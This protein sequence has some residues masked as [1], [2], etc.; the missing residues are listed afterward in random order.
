VKLTIIGP[1]TMARGIG[2]RALAGGNEVELIGTNPEVAQDLADELGHGAAAAVAVG[3]EVVVLALPY[4][5]IADAVKEHFEALAGR[6]VV[7]ISNPLDFASMDRVITPD[8]SSS[9]EETARL[10]PEN[11]TVVKAFNTTFAKP[12]VAGEA[13]GQT[14]DVLI[15]GDDDAAKAKVASLVEAGGMRTVDVGPLKRARMLEQVGLFHIAVQDQTGTGF[16]SALKL[17]W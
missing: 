3:G 7:D 16:T 13:G 6:V 1:G 5:Q 10:V 15:A 12:L 2:A 11:T 17:H 9:A 14:L 8:G 4:E